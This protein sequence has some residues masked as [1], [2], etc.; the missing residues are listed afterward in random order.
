MANPEINVSIKYDTLT[1]LLSQ[2]KK[3]SPDISKKVLHKMGN[4]L[5]NWTVESFGNPSLRQTKWSNRRKY[6]KG[7]GYVVEPSNLTDVGNL[8]KSIK[9]ENPSSKK[10]EVT[11]NIIY[12]AAH[13]FG[14][15]RKGLPARPFFPFNANGKI[16]KPAEEEIFKAGQTT[17]KSILKKIDKT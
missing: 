7:R 15:P 5:K 13:Q 10:V 4:A 9:M 11:S 14:I 3:Q 16:F 1:P 17:L 12:A 2:L 8:K 6:Y